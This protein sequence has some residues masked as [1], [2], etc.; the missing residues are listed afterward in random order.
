MLWTTWFCE[1]AL[2]SFNR[3]RSFGLETVELSDLSTVVL[4]ELSDP[5]SGSNLIRLAGLGCGEADRSE[6]EH[7][8]INSSD[9]SM[10]V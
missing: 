3:N 5:L 9:R 1:T 4:H 2:S 8:L 7:P 10:E 6:V